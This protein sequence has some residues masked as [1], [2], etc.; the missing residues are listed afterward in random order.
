MFVRLSGALDEGTGI[1]RVLAGSAM[2]TLCQAPVES[3]PPPWFWALS[4]R[5]TA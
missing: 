2:I 3:M 4:A 1:S 5:G